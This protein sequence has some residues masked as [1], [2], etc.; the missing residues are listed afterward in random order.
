MP[1]CVTAD[2]FGKKIKKPFSIKMGVKH[3]VHKLEHI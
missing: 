2:G 3:P 1:E